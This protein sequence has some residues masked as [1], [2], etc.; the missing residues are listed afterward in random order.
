[1]DGR[2]ADAPKKAIEPL[3]AWPGWKHLRFALFL[4]FV[5]L[6]WFILMYGGADALTSHRT[7]RVRVHLDSELNIPFVPE[8]I[9][10]Y[11]SLYLYFV[12]APFILRE[13]RRLFSFALTLDLII[14]IGGICFLL[15]P[16]R[17]AFPAPQNLGTLPGL[18]RLADRVNLTYNLVPSLHVAMSV[19][20]SATF[21]ARAGVTGKVLFWM[22]ALA[23]AVST[24]LTHQHHLLDVITGLLLGF[25]AFKFV[26][27]PQT[28]GGQGR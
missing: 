17:L 20:C 7:L 4:G 16:A 15:I 12:A 1:M 22:W 8:M 24:L 3:F 10:V 14:L 27:Y 25:G 28:T 21:A 9:L 6:W 2:A 13:R 19:F 26:Y 11:I 5:S 23:V 18:F